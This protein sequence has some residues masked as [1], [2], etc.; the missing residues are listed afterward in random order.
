M[1]RAGQPRVSPTRSVPG[2]EEDRLAGRPARC[3]SGSDR[4]QTPGATLEV[5]GEDAHP[6]RRLDAFERTR[7]T[8]VDL[9][10]PGALAVP[11]EVHAEQPAQSELARQVRADRPRGGGQRASLLLREP[12][13]HE[14]AAPRVAARAEPAVPDQLLA[15]AEHDGRAPVGDRR[16]RAGEPGDALLHHDVPVQRPAAPLADAASAAAAHRL[17]QPAARAIGPPRRVAGGEGLRIGEAGRAQGG[18]QRQ[19]G[20]ARARASRAGTR[21]GSGRTPAGRRAPAGSRA[22]RRRSRSAPGSPPPRPPAPPS[23]H[24]RRGRAA[25]TRSGRAAAG[26]SPRSGRAPPPRARPSPPARRACAR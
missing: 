4:R 26:R 8:G 13:R 21:A 16:G 2:G 5:G 19:P 22:P 9:D 24:G 3:R 7:G 20:R 17:A 11:H 6:V 25:R 23:R 1:P 18:A 12:R 10:D 15:H 14:V